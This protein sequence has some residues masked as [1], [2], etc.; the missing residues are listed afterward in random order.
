MPLPLCFAASGHPPS[1]SQVSLQNYWVGRAFPW[2]TRGQNPPVEGQSAIGK[3][4]MIVGPM[5]M[6]KLS[7]IDLEFSPSYSACTESHED[8]S[9]GVLTLSDY[10]QELSNH[11]TKQ[12]GKYET[13]IEQ[14]GKTLTGW[15]TTNEALKESA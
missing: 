10:V 7:A 4:Q 9:E 14:F 8:D 11:L 2:N 1:V 13:E 6:S 3:C 15:V 5:L 12:T